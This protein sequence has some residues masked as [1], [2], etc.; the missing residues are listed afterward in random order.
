MRKEVRSQSTRRR[1]VSG[2]D[3]IEG[4]EGLLSSDESRFGFGQVF[5]AVPLFAADHNSDGRHLLLLLVR[6]R[7]L[8]GHFLSFNPHHLRTAGDAL[9]TL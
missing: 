8:L 6:H 4:V 3:L 1:K 2:A 7:L 5:F 9:Q